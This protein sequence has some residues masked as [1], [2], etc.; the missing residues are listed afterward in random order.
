MEHSYKSLLSLVLGTIVLAW[1]SGYD[2]ILIAGLFIGF[3]GLISPKTGEKIM[4]FIHQILTIIFSILQK[5]LLTI[6]YFF[7]FTPL[8]FLKR[9]SRKESP[10]WIYP[11]SKNISQIE[12]MW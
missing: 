1:I 7:L 3:I 8:A 11:A 4:Y 6:L 2:Q 5:V 12:K 9:R 10:K